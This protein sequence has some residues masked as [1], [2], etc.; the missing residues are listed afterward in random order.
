M[1]AE[2]TCLVV[3]VL[4]ALECHARQLVQLIVGLQVVRHLQRTTTIAV[5]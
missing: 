2:R 4:D 5:A 1:V 3:E